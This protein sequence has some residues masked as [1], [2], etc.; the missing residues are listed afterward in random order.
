MRSTAM[1]RMIRLPL[2]FWL[3][4]LGLLF[5]A[6]LVWAEPYKEAAGPYRVDSFLLELK[7]D[8]R[9]RAV[10][11]KVYLPADTEG[12]LPLVLV[13]HGFGGSR[14]GLAYLGKHWA[15]HGY[16]C[17]HMQH[18][19]SDTSTWREL[20]VKDRLQALREAVRKPSVSIDRAEDVPFVLDTLLRLDAQ[21]GTAFYGRIDAD[22]IGI[23]GHSYGAW[24]AMAAGGMTVGST[25]WK[26]GRSYADD[27]IRCM[28][29]LSPPI[30]ANERLY[31]ATYGTLK[32]PVLFM[33]GT[34]DTSII[35]DMPAAHRK[36]PYHTMPGPSDDGQPKYLINFNGADHMTFSGE[37]KRLLR[38]KVSLEDNK[39]FH[40]I[41]LQSTTAF[42][43]TY[44][45]GDP[46][47]KQWLNGKGFV[48]RVGDRGEVEMDVRK[49]E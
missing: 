29:P 34:L 22:Q 25:P 10:P 7:D 32:I 8:E 9:D 23:A 2:I 31:K 49:K 33:T 47:A 44:L 19:G 21:V 37:T 46:D 27:R 12:Q 30:I 14:E 13:S 18:L 26:D 42:L 24:T 6:K 5:T 40:R 17:V 43:D 45:L 38:S 41:I 1:N 15:S 48:D 36:I 20:P 3:L 39:A 11:I 4:L 28:L 16:L 35:S